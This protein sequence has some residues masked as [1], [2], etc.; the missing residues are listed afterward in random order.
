MLPP[1]IEKS[2]PAGH[3]GSAWLKSKVIWAF[4][5]QPAADAALVAR[6][7][8]RVPKRMLTNN[9]EAINASSEKAAM[10]HRID[11]THGE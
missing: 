10:I 7:A 1:P 11:T 2:S 5:V 9:L 4:P 3:A 8:V 6:T